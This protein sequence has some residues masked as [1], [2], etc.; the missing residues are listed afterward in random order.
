MAAMPESWQ[1][2][3][4]VDARVTTSRFLEPRTFKKSLKKL[5]GL[6]G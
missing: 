1:K 5:K 4:D 6:R 2:E 3:L